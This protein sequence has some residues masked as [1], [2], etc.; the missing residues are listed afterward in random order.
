M[1]SQARITFPALVIILYPRQIWMRSP[2]TRFFY[3]SCNCHGSLAPS[4]ALA[5]RATFGC[6]KMLSCIFVYET[7]I[8]YVIAM[9]LIFSFRFCAGVRK[10]R[11]PSR[12]V[13]VRSG[14][15]APGQIVAANDSGSFLIGRVVRGLRLCRG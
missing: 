2:T 7:F 12:V 6:A 11:Q 13:F 5:L 10:L 3:L 14:R 8:Y 15:L 4:L 1:I 9:F